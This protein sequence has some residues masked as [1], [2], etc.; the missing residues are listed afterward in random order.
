MTTPVRLSKCLK[1]IREHVFMNSH[2]LVIITLEDHLTPNLL[3]KVAEMA[4]EIFGDML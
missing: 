3:T 2:Y 4:T 1:S